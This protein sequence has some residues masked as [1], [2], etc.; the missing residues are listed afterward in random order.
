MAESSVIVRCPSCHAKLRLRAKPAATRKVRCPRCQGVFSPQPSPMTQDTG[1]GT[2]TQPPAE[3]PDAC[4]DRG[5]AHGASLAHAPQ[6]FREAAA[7]RPGATPSGEPVASS[8]KLSA[9]LASPGSGASV[10]LSGPPAPAEGAPSSE[11]DSEASGASAAAP[12]PTEQTVTA[13]HGPEVVNAVPSGERGRPPETQ[14]E[15][16]VAGEKADRDTAEDSGPEGAPSLKPSDPTLATRPMSLDFSLGREQ[17]FP[18]TRSPIFGPRSVHGPKNW[19]T[20]FA[21]DSPVEDEPLGESPER[22][23]HREGAGGND[24]AVG[25]DEPPPWE[26]PE[27]NDDAASPW[28]TPTSP[29]LPDWPPDP[30]ALFA[31]WEQIPGPLSIKWGRHLELSAGESMTN[32]PRSGTGLSP[33]RPEAP[34]GRP[35]GQAEARAATPPDGA[36]P[37]SRQGAATSP[38]Q[39]APQGPIS[40]TA[41]P[42]QSSGAL[43]MAP[44]QGQDSSGRGHVQAPS[45]LGAPHSGSPAA[46]PR[47]DGKPLGPTAGQTAGPASFSWQPV[48]SEVRSTPAGFQGEG[49]FSG[50][51]QNYSVAPDQPPLQGAVSFP[52]QG[53]IF[54]IGATS[55]PIGAGSFGTP[56]QAFDPRVMPA[57]GQGAVPT[58]G[59]EFGPTGTASS[60]IP[61]EPLPADAREVVPPVIGSRDDSE[62]PPDS[63]PLAGRTPPV[64]AWLD[65]AERIYREASESLFSVAGLSM[66]LS[67]LLVGLGIWLIRSEQ[68]VLLLVVAAIA[69]PALYGA[70]VAAALDVVQGRE[71]AVSQCFA[72]A[73]STAPS[74]AAGI[75][76]QAGVILLALA[77]GA[78]LGPLGV[79]LVLPLCA[80]VFRPSV[81]LPFAVLDGAYDPLKALAISWQLTSGIGFAL[82]SAGFRANFRSVPYRGMGLY[83]LVLFAMVYND[84][85]RQSGL[86][87]QRSE[88]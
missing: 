26:Q 46:W 1:S 63:H 56:Q 73:Y 19:A 3:K 32:A 48:S 82:L 77:G 61:L 54:P 79:V 68:L 42:A 70:P 72:K 29:S 58:V 39:A 64:T 7:A 57:S 67:V 71:P 33:Y 75:L 34:A 30:G 83:Q 21:A 31:P 87:G 69:A 28:K 44:L 36:S 66:L 53:G 51:P 17:R 27:E 18:R 20:G 52:Q 62:L 8:P 81:F 76:I 85:A 45:P 55:P 24:D 84:L 74:V 35:Q 86:G 65:R 88:P 60:I 50:T 11:A 15:R 37:E 59:T 9:N 12:Q 41:P 25:L 22:S 14:S 43:P 49:G 16:S 5:S 13:I 40:S 78:Q 38:W 2:S 23:E 10:S 80:V 4:F 6:Q 47:Q